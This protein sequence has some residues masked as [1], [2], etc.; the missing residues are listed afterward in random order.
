M[1]CFLRSRVSRRPHNRSIVLAR[2]VQDPIAVSALLVVRDYTVIRAHVNSIMQAM[3]D[4]Q[5]ATHRR[6][7]GP[8]GVN[9]RLRYEAKARCIRAARHLAR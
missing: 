2:I 3:I 1:E 6:C 5:T 9:E 8:A 7:R 4:R